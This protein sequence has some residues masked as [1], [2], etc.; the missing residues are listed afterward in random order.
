MESFR[1]GNGAAWLDLMSTLS[2]RY[3]GEQVDAIATPARLRAWLRTN[4]LEPR[5][6]VTLEDVVYA[7]ELRE[8]LHRLAV[9]AIRGDAPVASDVRRLNAAL[10]HDRGLQVS[11]VSDGIRPGRPASVGDALARLA[12]QAVVDLSGQGHGT[13]RACGD[14]TCAGIFLDTTGRRRWCADLSCGN[15][16]RVRAHRDRAGSA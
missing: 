10:E 13:L 12:R 15:R 5:S 4:D 3:H 6:A 1:T 9:T 8:S 2:G 14:D 11:R 7:A 16:M